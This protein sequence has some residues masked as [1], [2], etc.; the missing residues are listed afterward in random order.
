MLGL[1]L[2][3]YLYRHLPLFLPLFVPKQDHRVTEMLLSSPSPSPARHPCSLV[4]TPTAPLHFLTAA[5][6]R[7]HEMFI[8]FQ[9]GSI[10]CVY[11]DLFGGYTQRFLGLIPGSSFRSTAWHGLGTIWSVGNQTWVSCI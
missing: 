3:L 10:F 7:S 9:G 4:T 8:M 5:G 2:N 6:W 11:F 1:F